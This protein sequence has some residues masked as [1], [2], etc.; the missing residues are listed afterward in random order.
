MHKKVNKLNQVIIIIL[1]SLFA[2]SCNEKSDDATQKFNYDPVP[3]QFNSSAINIASIVNAPSIRDSVLLAVKQI[4]DAGGVLGKEFNAVIFQ[5]SS[6]EDA[7]EQAQQ[8]L[9]FDIKALSVSFSSRSKAVSELSITKQIPLISESATSPFF[10]NYED[11]DFYFR[12]VPSD[13]IQ[14]RILAELAIEQGFY[15]AVTVHN[16]NDQYGETL[17][18][19]FKLN[20]EQLEGQVLEQLV[21]PFSLTAGFDELLQVI[22]NKAPDIVLDIILE[23]DVAAN[24]VNESVA[25]GLQSQFLF[26]DSSAGVA[27]FAN[28]IANV[29]SIQGSLGTAPGFGL[30]TNSELIFFDSSYQTQF[31]RSP[32]AFDVN[33][34][35]YALVTALAI[36]HA[37]LINNTDNPSGLMVRDSLRIVMNPPGIKIGP[38]NIAEAF[39]LIQSGQDIDY[40]GSYGQIDWDEN[41]DIIGEVTFNIM[42][43]DSQTKAWTTLFQQQIF[44]SEN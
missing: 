14:S 35:D 12:M 8:L 38:S 34:Y 5:S 44:I 7:V 17:V 3:D 9:T 4:N 33:A 22:E 19:Y 39:Q 27:A 31:N 30:I 42:N 41:G 16:E 1:M 20:F 13:I 28:N 29:D 24:F 15:T 40:S 23:A 11:Q 10:T 32:Y 6:T 26:P 37:G 36:E 25:F 18:E 43:V 21:A 2:I